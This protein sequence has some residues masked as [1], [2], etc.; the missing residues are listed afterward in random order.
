MVQAQHKE[1]SNEMMSLQIQ[2]VYPDNY[3]N[4]NDFLN[5]YLIISLDDKTE[6]YL[7]DL[8]DKFNKKKQANINRIK[9]LK[10]APKK[11]E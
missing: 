4:A 6:G 3:S 1:A 5:G 9:A 2:P 11:E 8:E 7:I 10:E